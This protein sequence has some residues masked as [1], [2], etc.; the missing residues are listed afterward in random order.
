MS[1]EA[2]EKSII[3]FVKIPAELDAKLRYLCEVRGLRYPQDLAGVL[4]D[5]VDAKEPQE[6]EVI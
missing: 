6:L 3:E 5:V 1:K 4:D 2:E